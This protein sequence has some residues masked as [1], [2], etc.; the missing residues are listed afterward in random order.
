MFGQRLGAEVADIA[1]RHFHLLLV[2]AVLLS[3]CSCSPTLRFLDERP[4]NMQ[5]LEE[6]ATEHGV[7]LNLWGIYALSEDVVLLFGGL[8]TGPGTL[9][10][11]LL[12]SIDGGSHWSEVMHPETASDVIEVVFVEGGEGWALVLWTVEGPGPAYLYHTTDWGQNWQRL[13]KLPLYGLGAHSYPVGLE[14][15][16]SRHGYVKIL[17]TSRMLGAL[18]E[19]CCLYE[20]TDGGITW[21]ETGNC[22]TIDDCRL[23]EVTESVAGDGSAWRVESQPD[24]TIQVSRRLPSEGWKVVS[25]IPVRF[26]YVDGEIVAP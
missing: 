14:F 11:V 12:R 18:S 17:A 13:S 8:Y 15:T 9:R 1:M 25:S 22:F 5:W 23:N 7:Y 10:S 24:A 19:C 4:K 21:N 16:D 6:V 26:E 20:T 3:S 2:S